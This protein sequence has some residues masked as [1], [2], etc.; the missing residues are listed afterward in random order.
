MC[1]G[2]QRRRE[3]RVGST[4]KL[5]HACRK[6]GLEG[7]IKISTYARSALTIWREGAGKMN[8]ADASGIF[9]ERNRKKHRYVMI[10][11][12][13]KRYACSTKKVNGILCVKTKDRRIYDSVL[14]AE[15][16]MILE[17]RQWRKL[18]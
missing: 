5:Y 15:D 7:T 9:D 12:I 2:K 17:D 16:R 3:L 1:A 8:D 4:M 6:A 14:E 11:R 10:G 13:W 18:D